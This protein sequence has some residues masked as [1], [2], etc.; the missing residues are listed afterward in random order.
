AASFNNYAYV[1]IKRSIY[2]AIKK[3]SRVKS[4]SLT[5]SISLDG[6]GGIAFGNNNSEKENETLVFVLPSKDLP[7]DEGMI[8]KE[9]LK[10]MEKA[11]MDVLSEFEKEVLNLFLEGRTYANIAEN[12][13]KKPASIENALSRIRAK[14]APFKNR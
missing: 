10:E 7:P 11:I 4:K 5:E 13:G 14:L 9:D 8:L 6:E 2:S 12:L 3:Y 1:C